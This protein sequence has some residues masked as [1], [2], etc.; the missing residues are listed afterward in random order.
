M[1]GGSLRIRALLETHLAGVAVVLVVLVLVGG[2]LTYS[3]YVAPGTTV[4]VE[5]TGSWESVGEFTHQAT[6]ESET[7]PFPEGTVLRNRSVYVR[8]IAPVLDGSFRYRYSASEGGD[9]TA[10]VG[11]HAL[12]RSTTGDGTDEG[13]GIVLWSVREPLAEASGSLA[14]GEELRVPFSANVSALQER[15]DRIQEQLGITTGST[16]VVIVATVELAGTRNG[17]SVDRTRT[18]R[19]PVTIETDVYRVEDPG[20]VTDSGTGTRR[21]TV[22]A[23]PGPLRAVGGPLLLAMGLAGLVAVLAGRYRGVIPL[24]DA[25]R[26]WITYRRQRAEYDDWI[27]TGAVPD[28]RVPADPIEVHDLEGLVDVAIDTDERVIEDASRGR[29]VVLAGETAYV[30]DGPPAPPSGD[31][32]LAA[33]EGSSPTE[34][35]DAA[36][37]AGSSDEEDGPAADG[38]SE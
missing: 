12:I 22:S 29:F 23:S 13:D 9:L 38:D 11:V 2:Y 37:E 15:A 25:E 17:E 1:S 21:V 26:R 14:P 3:G 33:A 10:D 32:I 27:T 28:G 24:S 5:E 34:S 6:V 7:E 36:D 4:E 35:E 30:Y 31:E 19:L 18:Y 8:E 20:P 16:E